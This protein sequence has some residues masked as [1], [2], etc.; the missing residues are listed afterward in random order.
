MRTLVFV[1]L[2]LVLFALWINLWLVP[3]AITSGVKAISDKC[4]QEYPV[5][6]IWNGNFFC[7]KEKAKDAGK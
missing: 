5:E 7:S 6:V 1:Q 3:S 4:G 2:G